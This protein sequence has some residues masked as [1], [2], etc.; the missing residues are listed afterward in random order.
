MET[1]IQ[2]Q[3]R[4]RSVKYGLNIGA[5]LV[6]SGDKEVEN[7]VP[8]PVCRVH[9]LR[10]IYEPSILVLGELLV[11]DFQNFG[12]LFDPA[13]SRLKLGRRRSDVVGRR[14]LPILLR[15]ANLLMST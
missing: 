1:V 15:Q 2:R 3:H 14:W 13:H 10:V 11:T 7:A 12:S 9:V 8:R 6:W 4:E 5:F